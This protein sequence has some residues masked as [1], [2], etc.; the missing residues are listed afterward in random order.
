MQPSKP[1]PGQK[2]SGLRQKPQQPR[3]DKAPAPTLG[4][5]ERGAARR[6][7]GIAAPV[8]AATRRRLGRAGGPERA[9]RR[10]A[11]DSGR[12]EEFIRE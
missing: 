4:G 7:T 11:A 2:S 9:G 12:T 8:A 6:E 3:R 1:R 5:S 10:R